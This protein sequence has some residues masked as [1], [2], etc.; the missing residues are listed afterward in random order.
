MTKMRKIIKWIKM[1]KMQELLIHPVYFCYQFLKNRKQNR[2][3]ICRLQN[4]SF[5]FWWTFLFTLHKEYWGI[6][7]KMGSK[8][9]KGTKGRKISKIVQVTRCIFCTWLKILNAS[10]TKTAKIKK[11]FCHLARNMT[12]KICAVGWKLIPHWTSTPGRRSI[13]PW[14][15]G[16]KPDNG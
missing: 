12:I 8:K 11:K 2:T 6:G 1:T 3:R 16:Q 13:P 15:K 9:R 14:M 10:V 4:H 5:F 7:E